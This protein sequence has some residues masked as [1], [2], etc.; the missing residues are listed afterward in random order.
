MDWSS[1]LIGLLLGCVLGALF[2][3]LWAKGRHMEGLNRA[4]LERE[5]ERGLAARQLAEKEEALKQLGERARAGRED[6]NARLHT[7]AVDLRSKGDDVVRLSGLLSQEQERGRGLAEKLNEQKAE[8]EQL[9]T[10]MTTEF[11]NIANRLLA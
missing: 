4:A 11:E 5:Q 6:L 1:L 8:L 10:C 3:H 7:S 9:Q 2:F